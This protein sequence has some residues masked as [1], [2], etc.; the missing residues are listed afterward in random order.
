MPRA[1]IN[2]EFDARGYVDRAG[3]R[4]ARRGFH[5][6]PL[7]VGARGDDSHLVPIFILRRMIFVVFLPFI[8]LRY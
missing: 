3:P 5:V 7:L 6:E 4:I 8:I 2:G 1:R